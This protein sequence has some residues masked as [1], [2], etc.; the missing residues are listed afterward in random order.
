MGILRAVAVET[1]LLTT[2]SGRRYIR[3]F[4]R[5]SF[6]A[7][8]SSLASF[9]GSHA[10][11]REI[12]VV[13]AWRYIRVPG[14]PGNEATSSSP[15]HGL[16]S[17]P[18]RPRTW[19]DPGIRLLIWLLACYD[20]DNFKFYN[21]RKLIIEDIVCM[22]LSS[23]LDSIHFFCPEITPEKSRMAMIIHNHMHTNIFT[24]T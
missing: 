7:C 3:T 19:V 21:C 16:V 18:D 17:F 14:E 20:I 11:E 12:E 22:N 9:P 1:L 2:K 6:I 8:T 5:T 15:C 4:D 24:A 23:K 10:R 13:Q